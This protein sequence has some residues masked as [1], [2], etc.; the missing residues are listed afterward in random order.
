MSCHVMMSC[1]VTDGT[2]PKG[3]VYMLGLMSYDEIISRKSQCVD[4]VDSGK[5]PEADQRNGSNGLQQVNEV[6]IYGVL[7]IP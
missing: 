6:C 1:H 3:A 4:T 7:V 5:H 2:I